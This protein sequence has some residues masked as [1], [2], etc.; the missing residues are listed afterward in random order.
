MTHTVL[1]IALWVVRELAALAFRGRGGRVVALGRD[2]AAFVARQLRALGLEPNDPR[3]L[4]L[5]SDA[6]HRAGR[7]VGL[8][9]KQLDQALHVARDTLGRAALEDALHELAAAA[10]NFHLP[11]TTAPPST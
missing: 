9:E 11:D 1:I 5:L 4:E 7:A 8:S 10:T 3:V 2:A 6:V